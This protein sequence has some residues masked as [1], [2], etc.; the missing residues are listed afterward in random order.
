MVIFIIYGV[1]LLA[2]FSIMEAVRK[3]RGWLNR[4]DGIHTTDAKQRA[5]FNAAGNE[6]H[7]RVVYDW[8]ATN[9]ASQ[10]GKRRR[11]RITWARAAEHDT[12]FTA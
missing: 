7:F 6:R 10:N 8:C 5:V 11:R 1:R 12:L 2:V 9:A 4:N 3:A